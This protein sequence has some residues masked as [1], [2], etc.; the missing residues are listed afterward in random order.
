MR[1]MSDGAP[2]RLTSRAEKLVTR[3]NSSLRTSRPKPI[4]TRAPHQTAATAN[5]TWT[6]V[7]PSMTA[8]VVRM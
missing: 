2:N 5:T 7:T 3:W 6:S 4:A 1:V 8:P